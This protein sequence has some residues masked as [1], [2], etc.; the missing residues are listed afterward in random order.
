MTVK[1]QAPRRK[2]RSLKERYDEFLELKLQPF[3]FHLR[4]D[5]TLVIRP[6]DPEE[7]SKGHDPEKI[8][9][10][11]ATMV[12]QLAA[13]KEE[14]LSLSNQLNMAVEVQYF[15]VG[16]LNSRLLTRYLNT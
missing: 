6:I 5:D 16:P 10:E 1:S 4:P 14:S 3:E 15:Y 7:V 8:S 2:R 13:Q 12:E 11:V 9:K